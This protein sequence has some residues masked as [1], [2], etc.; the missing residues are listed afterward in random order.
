MDEEMKVNLRTCNWCYGIFLVEDTSKHIKCK[1][2]RERFIQ[3]R[4]RSIKY[5]KTGGQKDDRTLQNKW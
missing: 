2:K 1:K 5:D 4:K 3:G